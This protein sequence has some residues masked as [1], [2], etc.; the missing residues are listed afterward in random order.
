MTDATKLITV[1][2]GLHTELKILVGAANTCIRKEVDNA[3]RIHLDER[4][5]E[6]EIRKALSKVS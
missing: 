4:F 3:L 6:P 5:K 1:S 2:E